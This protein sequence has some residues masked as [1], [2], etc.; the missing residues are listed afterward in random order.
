M[1][2]VTLVPRATAFFPQRSRFSE[3]PYCDKSPP[4]WSRFGHSMRLRAIVDSSFGGRYQC[5]KPDKKE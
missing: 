5:R 3:R 2:A 4:E 1:V